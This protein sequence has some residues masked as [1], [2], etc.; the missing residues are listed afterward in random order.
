MKAVEMGDVCVFYLRIDHA[1]VAI[2]TFHFA[3]LVTFTGDGIRLST[4]HTCLL[5]LAYCIADY[6]K[7]VLADRDSETS[8][9]K[10]THLAVSSE[11]EQDS[12]LVTVIAFLAKSSAK[13]FTACYKVRIYPQNDLGWKG[14]LEFQFI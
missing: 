10:L 1:N 6:Q 14:N 11:G 3:P 2:L 9:V 12:E 7:Q 8:D 5:K 4:V 13:C